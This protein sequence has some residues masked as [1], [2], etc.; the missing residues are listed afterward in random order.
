M[1]GDEIS[2][3]NDAFESN[4]VAPLGANVNLFEKKV[5]EFIGVEAG[6]AVSSGTAG[7]HLALDLLGVGEGD[8]VFC[9]SLTFAASAF[10][11]TYLGAV[12]VF[13]DSEPETWNMSPT[14]LQHAFEVYQKRGL[15]PKAVII[16][17]LY[18]QSADMDQLVPICESFGVPIIEDAAE[19]LG[20]V[21]KHKMSGT[22][23]T[24]SIFSFNGN[25]IITTSGGGMIVSDNRTLIN[26]ALKK[27]TQAREAKNY[28]EHK[29]IGYNYRLSNVSAGIGCGQMNVI[30]ER[31]QQKRAIFASYEE[32]L[33]KI[34]G[35]SFMPEAPET[36]HTR[37][38]TTV[39]IDAQVMGLS[40]VEIIE[41]LAVENIE[42]RHVWK[43]M[44]LQPIYQ[45]NEYFK[46]DGDCAGQLFREGLCLPSDTHM[47]LDDIEKVSN[48]IK[49]AVL[50]EQKK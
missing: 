27:A 45:D 46:H 50:S 28:Y 23:G 41:L 8:V 30:E 19:S 35:I 18:G 32:R 31:I 3:V 42:A 40:P 21:Y 47:T 22:F 12:P 43:P 7:I 25:K 1:G 20:A 37:W 11:I 17:N 26:H 16:V 36:F 15:L 39:R 33:S 14:A 4:W 9:A 38:L 6:C 49:K 29:E 24:L 34:P 13:I 10:P 48:I 5:T 2:F 44:H